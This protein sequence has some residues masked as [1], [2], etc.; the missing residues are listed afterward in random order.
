MTDRI[1]KPELA[2]SREPWDALVVGSGIGGLGAAALLAKAGLKTLVL[3]RHYVS[4]GFTHTFERKG[5]QWDV[6]IHYIGEVHRKNALLRIVSDDISSGRLHWEPMP[7]VYDRPVFGEERYEFVAG[8]NRLQQR[9]KDYFPG[10]AGAIDRYF[11]LVDQVAREAKGYFLEKAL[12]SGLGALASPFL[13]RRFLKLSD[14][15]TWDVLSGLTRNEKLI[16]VLTAQYGDYGLPPRQSSFAVHAIVARHYFEGG[17]YPVG[18]AGKI[19][20]TVAS[21]I[22][23]AGGLVLVK[24]EVD[25]V[26]TESGRACGV[27]MAN[28]DE[29]RAKVV[30]SDTGVF[31]TFGKLLGP[32]ANA[33][34]VLLDRLRRVHP[35]YPHVC[36]Y[37]GL[38]ESAAA[39]N[40]PK[41]NFWIYPGYDHD[42]NLE[43]YLKDRS[44]PL[45]V[46]YISFPSAKDPDWEKDHPGT[47]TIEAVGVVPY[48]WFSH[49]EGSRWRKRGSDYEQLKNEFTQRLLEQVYRFVPQVKDKIDY[50]ELSTPLS[51]RHFA[52]YGHGEIYGIDHTPERFRL[53]WLRPQTPI[54]NLF[55]TGQDICTAGYG[56]ALMGAVLAAS[57]VLRRNVIKEIM[58]RSR[59]EL[60][61]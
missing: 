25:K 61:S 5:Y 3:E 20:E 45:P 2:R 46:T 53:R 48:E 8:R 39:L 51:T 31:N 33:G 59:R 14:R 56:G 42:A 35:S 55:L 54:K 10:E 28:G 30:L 26:L 12:P 19:A 41:S 32:D 22:E 60:P 6:G 38:K 7:D 29:I 52:N 44:S 13:R 40:L 57:A 37:M 21:V 58:E 17:N 47:A 43:K 50:A 15:T 18:G 49:W 4:G 11:E 16:G 24:A 23:E 9:L 34:R 36:L 1:Y 27:R